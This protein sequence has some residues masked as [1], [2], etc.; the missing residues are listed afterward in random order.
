VWLLVHLDKKKVGQKLHNTGL[1]ISAL[2][3]SI[4]I[5]IKKYRNKKTNRHKTVGREPVGGKS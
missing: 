4:E 5:H 2:K 1:K 3:S